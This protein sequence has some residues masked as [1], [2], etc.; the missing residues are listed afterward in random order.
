MAKNF[1]SVR[2]SGNV[3]KDPEVTEFTDEA[4]GVV[5]K[6]WKFNV[7]NTISERV[8]GEFIDDT[9]WWTVE[10]RGDRLPANIVKGAFVIVDGDFA[11]IIKKDT[12]RVYIKDDGMPMVKIKT[13]SKGIVVA[14]RPKSIYPG[15]NNEGDETGESRPAVSPLRAPAETATVPDVDELPF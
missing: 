9:I 8:K 10:C 11:F 15:N 1:R 4:T 5:S 6:S 12:G 14:P 13:N 2:I 3:G 7:A